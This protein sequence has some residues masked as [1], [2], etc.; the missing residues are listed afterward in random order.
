MP[1]GCS[2]DGTPTRSWMRPHGK[3]AG[4]SCG[5]FTPKLD[6]GGVHHHQC[7]CGGGSLCPARGRVRPPYLQQQPLAAHHGSFAPVD[8]FGEGQL[9]AVA[10]QHGD[11]GGLRR[12]PR[13]AGTEPPGPRGGG[14]LSPCPLGTCSAS[15][16][17]KEPKR[18]PRGT[19][20][21]VELCS[22]SW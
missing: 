6:L 18:L 7:Q 22:S 20:Q 12:D 21:K 4:L 14:P 8:G 10:Q 16:K 17:R 9:P 2:W 3:A 15:R 1:Q 5:G 11:A 13:Q 19:M